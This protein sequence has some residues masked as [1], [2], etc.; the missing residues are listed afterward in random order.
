MEYSPGNTIPYISRV[1]AGTVEAVRHWASTSCR[2]AIS[3]SGSRPS[4]RRRAA[5]PIAPRPSALYRIK[6]R[7]FALVRERLA[8]RDRVT[9]LE[10]QQAMVGWLR[11][12]G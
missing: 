3:S 10:V 4:G 12:K 6:D 5:R 1:D 11:T 2:P 7:A 8:G 9:E